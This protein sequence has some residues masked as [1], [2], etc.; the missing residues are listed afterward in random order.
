[1]T[2]LS[3]SDFTAGAVY[4]VAAGDAVFPLTLD[5]VQALADSGREGGAFRLEFVGPDAPVLP[6]A[7]YRFAGAGD[8][9][10]IFIVPIARDAGGVRYEAVFY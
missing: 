8:A 9:H 2:A 3:L 6:Q 4:D 1:M 10:E 5:R 7:I